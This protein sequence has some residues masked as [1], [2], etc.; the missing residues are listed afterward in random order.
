MAKKVICNTKTKIAKEKFK[1]KAQSF[2]I[3]NRIC[4]KLNK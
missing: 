1:I 4:T 3:K 2:N